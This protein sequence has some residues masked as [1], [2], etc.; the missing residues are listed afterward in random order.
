MR[1]DKPV[2]VRMKGL[3]R[4]ALKGDLHT[5]VRGKLED[6][7]ATI[8]I[9]VCERSGDGTPGNHAAWTPYQLGANQQQWE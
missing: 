6:G 9:Y 1:A 5:V 2:V 8:R 7:S 3:P 4:S